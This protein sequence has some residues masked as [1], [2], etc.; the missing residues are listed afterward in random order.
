M[1][2]DVPAT[3][4]GDWAIRALERHYKKILKHEKKVLLDRDPEELHQMRVG[5]RR[6]RT[7]MVGFSRAVVLPKGVNE[8][9]IGAIARILG[10]LR[11]NDVLQASLTQDYQSQL[12]EKEQEYVQSVLAHLQQ[13][14]QRAVQRTRKTL[15]HAN[16][17][18]LK[19]KLQQWLA[20]PQ[21]TAI[22]DLPIT[23]V[24][25]D[26]L[27]PQFS[28]LLLHPGWLVG[29]S[30]SGAIPPSLETLAPEQE[31]LL[32]DLRKTAKRTRYQMEL[33][34]PFYRADYQD[35]LDKI[36][37]LQEI[38]GAL[39]DSCVLREM[40]KDHDRMHTPEPMPRFEDCLQH[41]RHQYWLE[42]LPLQSDFLDPDHRQQYRTLLQ[43]CQ[44]LESIPSPE[45]IPANSG[46]NDG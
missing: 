23:T 4:F 17:F 28:Q 11:D 3:S 21:L 20:A 18:A 9:K 13:Q 15:T 44:A 39:Q 38:L 42:W 27:L 22:A 25:P 29:R 32:H 2:T 46:E 7:A 14:R 6:L 24:L 16:Y 34:T 45:L 31:T 10:Q 37:A 43:H 30:L 26:L 35:L 5:M 12:P 19:D 41:H 36:K 33:F 1:K 8:K 40:V